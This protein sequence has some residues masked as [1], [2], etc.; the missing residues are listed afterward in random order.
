MHGF[1]AQAHLGIQFG[2][3]SSLQTN[4]QC[5]AD[6]GLETAITELDVR[7]PLPEGEPIQS[8]LMRQA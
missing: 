1:S 2:F 7:M 4:L 5:F 8:Q 6:L 3:D